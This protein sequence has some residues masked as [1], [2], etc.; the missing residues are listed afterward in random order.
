MAHVYAPDLAGLKF[1]EEAA[2]L[3]REVLAKHGPE[4][5]AQA[6]FPKESVKALQEHGFMGL[7]LPASVGGKG[8]SFRTFIAVTEEL[9]QGCASTAMIYVMH[10]SAAQSIAASTLAS[11]DA[12]LREIAAGKHLTTLALSEKGSRSQFW[13]PVSKLTPT[14]GGG[15]TT[16]A[17]KSWSTSASNAD[18]YV[19]SAQ[20]PGAA[21]P[22]ESTCYLMR[23]GA[24]GVRVDSRFDGLGLRGND[25]APVTVEAHPVA[26][27]DLL[28][29]HGEGLKMMLELVLPWFAVG[30]AAMSAGVCRA[31]L[32]ATLS[33]VCS[34]SFETGGGLRDLVVLRERIAEM[35][36]RTEQARALI[37]HTARELEQPSESTTLYVLQSRLSALE[38]AV[39]VTDLAMKTCGG[40][41][42][43]K[44]LPVERHFRDA[45]AGWVMAPTADHLRDFLGKALTGLPLF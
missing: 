23:K 16:S 21:K 1:V 38:S 41:A 10:V 11:K 2:S 29:A 13:L 42:Y 8:Q 34:T 31:A 45:R 43:S 28:T 36:M 7:C 6:R 35:S 3:A 20:R 4:V 33:H 9:A 24:K 39:T 5:D 32:A 17:K 15:Y 12:L 30:S 27:A 25:S 18:S 40:A 26:E 44:H 22:I 37:A 19:S 14:P